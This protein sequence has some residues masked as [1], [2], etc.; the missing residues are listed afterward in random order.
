MIDITG[1]VV[2]MGYLKKNITC[3]EIGAGNQ[4]S[5]LDIRPDGATKPVRVKVVH[6]S[7]QFHA[8]CKAHMAWAD[9][10]FQGELA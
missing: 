10:R 6:G 2:G 3:A 1:K 8:A 4:P 9:F 5:Y 7:E